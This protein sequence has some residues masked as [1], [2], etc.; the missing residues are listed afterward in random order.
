[1]LSLAGMSTPVLALND[2]PEGFAEFDD[3]V[4]FCARE[5]NVDGLF[6]DFPDKARQ[7]LRQP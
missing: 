7:S 6:T 1:M 2:L 3:L 4:R 5:L